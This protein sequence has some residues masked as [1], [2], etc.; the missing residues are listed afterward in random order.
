MTV[1]DLAE[2]DFRAIPDTDS[3]FPETTSAKKGAFQEFMNAAEFNPLLMEATLQ[4]DTIELGKELWGV[5]VDIPA[6]RAQEKALEII[7]KLLQEAP[8]P[9]EQ[10]YTQAIA[11]HAVANK[12]LLDGTQQEETPLPDQS[13]FLK[14]SVDPDPLM[15]FH[16]YMWQACLNWWNS[17]EKDQEEEAGNQ[18]GLMNVRLY[19]MAQKK[20]ADAEQAM[21]TMPPPAPAPGPAAAAP[22]PGAKKPSMLGAPKPAMP[23]VPANQPVM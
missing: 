7:S 18:Q 4:P 22:A 13:Q 12:G 20:F 9:D 2:G 8:G 3:S 21:Q 17:A 10:A 16:K 19:A 14:S 6:T 11:M 15:D 1:A 23:P 5:D